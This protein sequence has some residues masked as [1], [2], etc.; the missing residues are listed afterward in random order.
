YTMGAM[1]DIRC[2]DGVTGKVQWFKSVLDEYKVKPPVWG[3]ASH[4]LIDGDKF[5]C[6]VGGDDHAVV[7]LDK[8]TGQELWHALTVKEIGYAP[9][10]IVEAGGV[11]QLII[12]HTEAVNSLNPETGKLYWSQAFP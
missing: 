10:V 4:P 6:F 3:Y 7:A 9:P 11:R 8:N 1:G 2:L 5:I 12:Y